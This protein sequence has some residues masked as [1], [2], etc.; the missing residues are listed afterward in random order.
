MAVKIRRGAASLRRAF[1]VVAYIAA[2]VL[3]CPTSSDLIVGGPAPR[4]IR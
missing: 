1:H 3:S 2:A 4:P